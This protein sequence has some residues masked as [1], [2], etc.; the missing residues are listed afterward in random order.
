MDT[1]AVGAIDVRDLGAR[2]DE[3][4]NDT[5]AIQWAINAAEMVTGTVTPVANLPDLSPPATMTPAT[6]DT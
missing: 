2:G 3:N 4:A 6:P 1:A 5:E